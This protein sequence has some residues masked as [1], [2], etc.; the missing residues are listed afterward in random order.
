VESRQYRGK[1]ADPEFRKE[2][3]RKAAVARTSVDAHI[4][5]LVA[6]A[7]PLTAEQVA[8]LRPLLEGAGAK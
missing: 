5:A 6:K 3:A 7:P 1:L 4:D 8:K 2:R